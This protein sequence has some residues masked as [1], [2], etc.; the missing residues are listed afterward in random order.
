M[1]NITRYFHDGAKHRMGAEGRHLN[2]RRAAPV[3]P[4]DWVCTLTTTTTRSQSP[5]PAVTPSPAPQQQQQQLVATPPLQKEAPPASY[6]DIVTETL[7]TQPEPTQPQESHHLGCPA[8]VMRLFNI[9]TCVG[10]EA[11][12]VTP[13]G[14]TVATGGS[15]RNNSGTVVI[16]AVWRA[17]YDVVS[18]GHLLHATVCQR[19]AFAPPRGRVVWGHV[20]DLLESSGC[21]GGTGAAAG[22]LAWD[23]RVL[24][25]DP[26]RGD[27]APMAFATPSLTTALERGL[28]LGTDVDVLFDYYRSPLLYVRLELSPVA[29][30]AAA[31][32][33]PVEITPPE[34]VQS[35]STVATPETP[36]KANNDHAGTTPAPISIPT[37]TPQQEGEEPR[38]LAGSFHRAAAAPQQQCGQDWATAAFGCQ[39]AGWHD[40]QQSLRARTDGLPATQVLAV[41]RDELRDWARVAP[42]ELNGAWI[43][44]LR[45]HQCDAL[46]SAA[47][48]LAAA[49]RDGDSDTTTTITVKVGQQ[50]QQCS[51]AAQQVVRV[52]AKILTEAEDRERRLAPAH[53][54]CDGP[55]FPFSLQRAL[56][57]AL[58]LRAM[59]HLA[60]VEAVSGDRAGR[61]A[62]VLRAARCAEQL[63]AALACLSPLTPTWAPL[64]PV[65]LLTALSAIEV[66]R[67][68]AVHSRAGCR[69]AEVAAAALAAWQAVT[70]DRHRWAPRCLAELL[71]AVEAQS[72]AED[73]DRGELRRQT[74]AL[75][76]LLAGPAPQQPWRRDEP[77]TMADSLGLR[78]GEGPP[79]VGYCVRQLWGLQALDQQ[80]DHT[81][82]QIARLLDL[83]AE[84]Q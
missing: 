68:L 77:T 38:D 81:V 52:V 4:P 9:A 31:A 82:R 70:G 57:L 72:D 64:A 8:P 60:V 18:L 5:S 36:R 62:L 23:F 30:V 29:A 6:A 20:V 15:S 39:L 3:P 44:S 49:G 16:L 55:A 13:M 56:L 35:R 42:A 66:A 10:Y 7:A 1:P 43:I 45:E 67:C 61:Q 73:D 65:L 12:V 21:A 76:R 58:Q 37:L 69:L 53:G 17:T 80:H 63:A 59:R 41:V 46:I 75:R 83:T 34:R 74:A 48:Y 19:H 40:L 2:R 78:G 54:P 14:G 24:S 25:S 47:G 26:T 33:G 32:A 84:A 22:A 27:G 50:L 79:C 71:D 28:F 11:I 51:R